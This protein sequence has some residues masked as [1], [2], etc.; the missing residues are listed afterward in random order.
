MKIPRIDDVSRKNLYRAIGSVW[1]VQFLGSRTR[2]GPFSGRKCACRPQ[3][4]EPHRRAAGHLKGRNGVEDPRCGF[5]RCRAEWFADLSRTD[6]HLRT[7]VR[8][9]GYGFGPGQG[10]RRAMWPAR[11]GATGPT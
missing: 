2:R 3:L 10:N 6:H 4:P 11:D 9:R 1:F 8:L 5:T 7:S